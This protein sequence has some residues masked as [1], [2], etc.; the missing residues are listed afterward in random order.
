VWL[1]VDLAEHRQ[2]LK[3]LSGYAQNIGLAFQIVDDIDHRHHPGIRQNSWEGFA[4][5]KVTYP[6][7]GLEES[8]RQAQQLIEASGTSDL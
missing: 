7:L 5:A 6:S 1:V 4:S 2:H 8:Q 3:R